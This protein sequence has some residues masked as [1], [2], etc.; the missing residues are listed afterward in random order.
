MNKLICDKY[1]KCNNGK[2]TSISVRCKSM[3]KA[4][5]TKIMLIA[6]THIFESRTFLTYY[7]QL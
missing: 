7:E 2:F 3:Y 6:E 5:Q 1:V 4:E